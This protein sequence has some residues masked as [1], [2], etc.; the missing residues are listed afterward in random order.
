MMYINDNDSQLLGNWWYI[1]WLFELIFLV[2]RFG[3][4]RKL[5]PGLS[6]LLLIPV[7]NRDST[8]CETSPLSLFRSQIFREQLFL[9]VM[10][11]PWGTTELAVIELLFPQTM[12]WYSGKTAQKEVLQ[13]RK[14]G[15]LKQICRLCRDS[16]GGQARIRRKD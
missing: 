5:Y 4:S 14:K 13:L 12:A 11:C 9:S 7:L 15:F 8:V 2:F 16:S 6:F 10:F 3:G 1:V